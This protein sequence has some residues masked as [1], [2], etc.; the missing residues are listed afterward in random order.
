MYA[1]FNGTYLEIQIPDILNYTWMLQ[2]WWDNFITIIINTI[3]CFGLRRRLNIYKTFRRQ[4]RHPIYIY[5]LYSWEWAGFIYKKRFY[6]V[7]KTFT[8]CPLKLFGNVKAQSKRGL[9]F[10]A[11]CLKCKL[12]L[13]FIEIHI[14]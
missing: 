1:L 5:V 12:V 9:I 6:L 2:K 4:T 11:Q 10:V 13:W 8:K 7:R 3:F 14:L